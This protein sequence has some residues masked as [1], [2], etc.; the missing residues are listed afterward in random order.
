MSE[1]AELGA[2]AAKFVF[3]LIGLFIGYRI[4]KSYQKKKDSES[5]K[6]ENGGKEIV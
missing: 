2:Q 3:P 5:T 1:A 6:L 4:M